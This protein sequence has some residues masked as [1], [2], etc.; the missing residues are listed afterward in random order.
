MSV[1][2]L[3]A[4]VEVLRTAPRTLSPL[5]EFSLLTLSYAH[6][7]KSSQYSTVVQNIGGHVFNPEVLHDEMPG[8]MHTVIIA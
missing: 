3:I 6:Y 7:C 4:T 2:N 1:G 8:D 5:Q